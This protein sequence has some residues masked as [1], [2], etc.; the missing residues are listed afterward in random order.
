MTDALDPTRDF[1]GSKIAV[2]EPIVVHA[3][4]RRTGRMRKKIRHVKTRSGWNPIEAIA[5]AQDRE[6]V[7]AFRVVVSMVRLCS[8]PTARMDPM[9]TFLHSCLGQTAC[10][11]ESAIATTGRA[12]GFDDARIKHLTDQLDQESRA[13]EALGLAAGER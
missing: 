5:W 1:V 10:L 2:Y 4:D 8:D 3:P 12:L 13:V 9:H 7:A 11:G 6:H